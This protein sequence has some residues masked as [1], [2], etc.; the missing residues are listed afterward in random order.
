[1]RYLYLIL[2]LLA[3]S[4]PG[5]AQVTLKAGNRAPAFAAESLDGN[6]YD[7][8]A[9][10]GRVV[11]ITFWSTKCMI[12]RS[13]IP[14]L[15]AFPAKYDEAKVA[16]LAL[17]LE[18][19]EQITAYLKSNPFKFHIL[20][21]SFGVV[22]QYADRDKQGNIDMGFPSYFL[23]DEKGVVAYR[24]SGWDKTGEIASRIDQILAQAKPASS[25]A[26]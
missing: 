15:N 22:L 19:D 7:L 13:E 2:V 24:G 26:P 3:F 16:F 14:K 10:R 4:M 6:Y 21:N 1:M 25:T 20:P 5:A 18:S 17:T 23:I 11:L 8:S 9:M 12:C